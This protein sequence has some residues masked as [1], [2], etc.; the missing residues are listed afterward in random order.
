MHFDELA[1]ELVIHIFR[2]CS[3]VADVFSLAATSRRFYQ[4]FAASQRLPILENAVES[5]FGPLEDAVQLVTHNESQP[6]HH[7]RC[8]PSSLALIKQVVEVGRVAKRWESVYP[9]KKW[10]HNFQDRRLLTD[11]ERFR[12]RRAVYRL[13]LYDRAF[14][15]R[16]H[17][18]FSRLHRS[19]VLE[20]AE[21][22]HNWST[23]ELADLEDVRQVFRDVLQNHVCPSNG[24]IQRKFRKRFPETNQQLTFNIHLNYPPPPTQFQQHFHTMHQDHPSDKFISKYIPT[25]HH[26]PGAEGWGDEI[27]HYYVV[28]DMLKLDPGQIMWLR[29]HA[30]LKGQVETYIRGLGEW[31]ENNGETFGQTLDWVMNERGEDAGELRDSIDY[32]VMGI[33][34]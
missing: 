27:P 2:S 8:V 20:R 29:D 28:E 21:L 30:P 14:H 34:E 17:P 24:T 5:E 6:A 31:F 32:G 16:L 3:S 15:N 1:T 7:I 25:Q 19:S 13:W 23:N 10:K 26:E 22:L 4:A 33:V 12:L 11:E 9:V 18:R